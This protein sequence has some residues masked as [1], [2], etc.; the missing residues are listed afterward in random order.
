MENVGTSHAF[1]DHKVIAIDLPGLG[2]SSPT[3]ITPQRMYR[4]FY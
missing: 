1:E 3:M 4:K 2:Q